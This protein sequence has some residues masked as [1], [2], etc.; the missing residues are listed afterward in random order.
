MQ[1]YDIYNKITTV[2][3]SKKKNRIKKPWHLIYMSTLIK[4]YSSERPSS[5]G[6]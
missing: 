2:S 5:T 3:F 6:I 4:T 1:E